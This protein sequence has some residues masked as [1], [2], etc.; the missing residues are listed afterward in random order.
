MENK[1]LT[2]KDKKLLNSKI[3]ILESRLYDLKNE[4]ENSN[5]LYVKLSP[6]REIKKYNPLF[7]KFNVFRKELNSLKKLLLKIL[8]EKRNDS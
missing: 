6:E 7:K 4:I 8:K 1:L 2:R 5:I 3:L